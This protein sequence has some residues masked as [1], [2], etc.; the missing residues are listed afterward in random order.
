[1]A[2]LLADTLIAYVV[3]QISRKING[4]CCHNFSDQVSGELIAWSLA[5]L[6]TNLVASLIESK[7]INKVVQS[8]EGEKHRRR[9]LNWKNHWEQFTTY[10]ETTKGSILYD[11]VGMRLFSNTAR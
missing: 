6:T 5:R 11:M 4:R 1:M 3:W 8:K 2:E 7:A 10:V 9:L